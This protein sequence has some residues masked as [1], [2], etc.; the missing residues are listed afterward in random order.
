MVG[1]ETMQITLEGCCDTCAKRIRPRKC[2]VLLKMIGEEEECWAWTDDPA[3][4][5]EVNKAVDA[6]GGS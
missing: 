1:G 6:Y 2:A 5:D 4:E 3:W